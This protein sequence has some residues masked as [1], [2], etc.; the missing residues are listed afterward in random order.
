[1]VGDGT[2]EEAAAD[3]RVRDVALAGGGEENVVDEGFR[4]GPLI[5][6]EEGYRPLCGSLGDR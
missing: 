6:G 2:E 3:T 1:M 4:S 5:I